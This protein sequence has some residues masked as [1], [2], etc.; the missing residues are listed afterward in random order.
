MKIGVSY[1]LFDGEEL[2]ESSIKSIRKNVDYISVVY[3][4][5]SNFGNPCDEGLVPLLEEL[6]SKGDGV[7][8]ILGEAVI[9]VDGQVKSR[10]VIQPKVD[11]K[12]WFD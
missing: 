5:V 10:Q 4:T 6:K 9:I 12:G 2:L 7:Y 3:Q 11:K 1:N 8:N